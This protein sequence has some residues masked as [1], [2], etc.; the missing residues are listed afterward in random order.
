MINRKHIC[1]LNSLPSHL[2]F[3]KKK[4]KNLIWNILI[5]K[6]EEEEV[7]ICLYKG[8]IAKNTKIV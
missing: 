2:K 8:L 6:E 5:K 7:H 1:A 3:L 4:K